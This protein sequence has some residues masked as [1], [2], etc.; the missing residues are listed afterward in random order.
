MNVFRLALDGL[1]RDWR[2]GEIRLIAA[3]VVIAVGSATAVSFFTNSVARALEREA[4]S[5]L[6]AD[7]AVESGQPLDADLTQRA[8]ELGLAHTLQFVFRSVV[9]A[10]DRLQLAEIKAVAPGYPLRGQ[11]ETAARPFGPTTRSTAIPAPGTIWADARLLQQLGLAAG[12]VVGVGALQLRID[13]VLVREPDRGGDLF[14]IAPR[15]IMNLSDIPAS[16]LVV[17]GSR[18]TYRLLLAGSVDAVRA[19]SDW[20]GQRV[21]PTERLITVRDARPELR[22]ALEHARQ[23]LGLAALTGIVLAGVAIGTAA[24]RHAVRHMD[25]SAILRCLGASAR[26]ILATATLQL[27]L[28]ALVAGAIGIVLGWA[29]HALLSVVLSGMIEGGLPAP[30][31]VDALRGWL[32]ALV[33]LLGFALPPVMQLARVPPLRVLR[34]D[35]GPPPVQGWVTYGAALAAMTALAPWSAGRS[36][37][38][39][40]VIAGCAATALVLAGL[41]ML[42]VRLL[43]VLRRHA[44]VSWRYGLASLAR[45]GSGSVTQIVSLGLG[46]LVMLLLTLVRGDLLQAWRASVPP[47]APNHFVINV[48]P[49]ERDRLAHFLA[50]HGLAAPTLYPMVRARLVAINGT[51]VHGDEFEDPRARRFIERDFNLAWTP[52]LPDDNRVTAGRW[53]GEQPARADQ[54]SVEAGLAETLGL[55]VG[56]TLTYRIADREI[57]GAITSLRTVKWD[58]FNVNFFVV[59]PRA[60]IEAFPATYLTNF[61]LAPGAGDFLP[62]MVREF[63]SI[64]VI[65][66]DAVMQQVRGMI[67]RISAAIQFVFAFTLGAGMLVLIAAMQATQDERVRESAVMRTLGAGSGALLRGLVAEFAVLGLVA[68]TVAG[69]AAS[70][71]GAL[72]AREV[73][74]VPYSPS[75]VP[76]AAGLIGGILCVGIV[77]LAG[78]R[79]ALRERPIVLLQRT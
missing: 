6:A 78:M 8:G 58:S 62:E 18:V 25:S 19:F 10:G 4:G 9:S 67:D 12:D 13:R 45:R 40:Y 3:A 70:I 44:S 24:Q 36:E 47:D 56:D 23:F 33:T 50:G 55:A 54:F 26:Q 51:A 5:L 29:G 49:D 11:V 14:S 46:L 43:L 22:S 79:A 16:R 34:R 48:Q 60:L 41:A 31:P 63:P 20:A 52:Q 75:P 2:S 17:P 68:G 21:R 53:W 27:V 76:I 38:T 30:D 74:A 32:V 28:L 65:D 35:L 39:L 77:G 66:V 57:T 71:A 15:L 73:F 7:V 42:L 61:H 64:S 69:V 59:A 37:V 72:L 1:L